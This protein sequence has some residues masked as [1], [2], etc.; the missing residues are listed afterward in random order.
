MK[1]LAQFV[2]AATLGMS[3][4]FATA[5]AI[6]DAA[7]SDLRTSKAKARDEYRNPQQTLR[8]FGL[9]PDM[10]V[11]EVS[12]GGGWYTDILYPVV[13]ESG[14]YV[15]AHFYVDENSNEYYKKALA[16]FKKKTEAGEKYQGA[17]VTAFHPT[18]ALDI[19][20]AGT[21]DMVLTFRNVHNWY[22]REGDEGID[23]AFGAFF[24]ALKPGGVLGVVE[25]E[26]PESAENDAMQKSGYMKR[27]Y[28]VAAAE[29]AGFVLEASSDVNANPMDSAD[30]PKGV[31]TLPPRLAL[32]DQDREKYMAIGESNRMT[33]KFIKPNK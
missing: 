28:V 31:W 2:L 3:S 22:M 7:M 16:A 33:L 29:K 25:H 5:D 8:F 10:T 20:D 4:G 21:A 12:P 1:K 27:S 24:T 14:K 19:I 18:K 13:K 32:D 26:L 30:H 17:T 23:N 15:A 9:Q 11:V 6:S